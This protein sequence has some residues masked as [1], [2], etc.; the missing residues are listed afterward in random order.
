[1]PKSKLRADKEAGNIELDEQTYLSGVPKIAWEYKLAIAAHWN[2]F[3]TNTKKRNQK[4]PQSP[5]ISTHI[6]SLI[7]KKK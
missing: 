7:I 4:I 2:G 1:L 6:N 5:R 3:W